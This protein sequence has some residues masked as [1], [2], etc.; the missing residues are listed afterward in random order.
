MSKRYGDHVYPDMGNGGYTSLHS[1][2]HSWAGS[3]CPI[4]YIGS[5][6]V[7]RP[8]AWSRRASSYSS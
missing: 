8:I 2:V 7:S 6:H 1:D 5:D 3:V 4:P